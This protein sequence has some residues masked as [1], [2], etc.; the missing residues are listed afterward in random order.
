MTGSNT[1]E[2]ALAPFAD[3]ATEVRV[4]SISQTTEMFSFVRKGGEFSGRAIHQDGEIWIEHKGQQKQRLASFLASADMANLDDLARVQGRIYD[5]EQPISEWVAG[6]ALVEQTQHENSLSALEEVAARMPDRTRIV[7]LDGPAGMGKTTLVKKLASQQARDFIERRRTSLM[8][9]VSSRGRRLSR[10]NDAIAAT[11]QDLR[12]GIFYPE[13]PILVKHGLL[14]L[15][16]DGFDEL[17]NQDGYDDAWYS[18]TELLDS[19]AGGG[20]LILSSRDTFFSDQEFILRAQRQDALW[21]GRIDFSFVHLQPWLRPQVRE[22]FR[23]QGVPEEKAEVALDFFSDTR[24]SALVRPFFAHRLAAEIRNSQNVEPDRLLFLITEG[25]L[26]RE[27]E[28]LLKDHP[29]GREVLRRF[30]QELAL[31]MR[32]Q[33]REVLDL[34]VIQFFL[35]AVL[36]EAGIPHEQRKQLVHRAGAV[37]FLDIPEGN[38]QRR[39]FPHQIIRDFFF[40]EYLLS[41]LTTDWR[42]LEAALQLGVLGLDLAD[43]I[44][45]IAGSLRT[46]VERARIQALFSLAKSLPPADPAALNAASLGFAL[47]RTRTT[48]DASRILA[49]GLYLGNVSLVGAEV[50]LL[51]L[52]GCSV[53]FLDLSDSN[54]TNIQTKNTT[55]MRLRVS[56]STILGTEW[57]SI[58]SAVEYFDGD[59]GK[60]LST[61]RQPD[62]IQS[63]LSSL[64]AD[65]IETK[66]KRHASAGEALLD[67]LA[68][69]WVRRFYLWPDDL[70]DEPAFSDPLWPRLR[71]ILEKHDRLVAKFQP[72]SGPRRELLHLKD[73]NSLLRRRHPDP[74]QQLV[75]DEI[76]TAAKSL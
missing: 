54:A 30:F 26:T 67:A 44:A 19:I 16:I 21:Q 48:G 36:E 53:G 35:D 13:V 72:T 69:R 64:G 58:P 71:S 73:P 56:A 66:S 60:G 9:I 1:L 61:N 42:R 62:E 5:R 49:D 18:L 12:V 74:A 29:S 6:P 4:L 34:D 25:F 33:E 28:L 38:R 22:F 39:G 50:P 55:V 57:H 17:V 3:P 24:A 7:V 23:L 47:L 11:L 32:Q 68:R 76:W 20:V 10:L 37:A 14:T 2:L 43:I 52:S 63:I 46:P 59:Y 15:V 51:E 45:E 31:E 70:D 8:L 27:A 41:A 75:I 65:Q 40:S